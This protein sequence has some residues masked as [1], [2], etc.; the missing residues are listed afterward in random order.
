VSEQEL[1]KEIETLAS[2]LIG[3]SNSKT[4]IERSF[5]WL[6]VQYVGRGSDSIQ[7]WLSD[8]YSEQFRT[9]YMNE[10]IDRL[11]KIKANLLEG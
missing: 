2:E 3:L 8:E 6:K 4:I 10:T 11:M 5:S 1:K 7:L 9:R